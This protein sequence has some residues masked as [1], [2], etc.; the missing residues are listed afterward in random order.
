MKLF[1]VTSKYVSFD[2]DESMVITAQ[3]AD[4]ALI[5]AKK[6]WVFREGKDVN[7]KEFI[8]EELDLN[9]EQIIEVSHYG[10]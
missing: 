5:L 10:D 9:K 3:N 6:N 4:N 1:K 7:R 8:I 2:E